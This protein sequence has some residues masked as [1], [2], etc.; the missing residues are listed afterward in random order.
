M[1]FFIDENQSDGGVVSQR[2]GV[3]N[4]EELCHTVLH[5]CIFLLAAVKGPDKP[6]HEDEQVSDDETD[7]VVGKA[8]DCYRYVWKHFCTSLFCTHQ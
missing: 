3:D 8:E 4:Y 5:R 7:K 1:I 6:W 2:A